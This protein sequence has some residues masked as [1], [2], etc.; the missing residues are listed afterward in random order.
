ML[1]VSQLWGEAVEP[2]RA[3]AI[4][5]EPA[6]ETWQ[7]RAYYAL[8]HEVF[9]REQGLF[10]DSDL[11]E[12]DERA[13]PL[14]AMANTAGVLDEVVG[15]VRIYASSNGLWYGGRLAVCPAYRRNP[16]VGT[17]LIRA[18]VGAARGCGA[19]QF[20]ATVQLGNVRYFERHHFR[21]LARVSVCG[22][23]H[24]LMQA[25]LAAFSVPAWVPALTAAQRAA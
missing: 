9:V 25:E 20:W 11:D 16:R 3:R 14:V 12:H 18:A 15:V 13:L 6:R 10:S 24:Q 21:A 7:R 19:T 5:A 17:A 8:R 1:S 2:F 22:E 4:V 23:P